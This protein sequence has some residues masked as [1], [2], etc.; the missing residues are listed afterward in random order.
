MGEQ[1][2]RE[3]S[4]AVSAGQ[5]PK[6]FIRRPRDT[7]SSLL[8]RTVQQNQF[9][10]EALTAEFFEPLEAMIDHKPYLLSA[11]E[12]TGP[13][14]LDCIALGYLSLALVPDLSSPWMRDAMHSK[15]PLLSTYTERLRR[16]CFGDAAVE[17]GHAFLLQP[18]PTTS[19]LPWRAPERISVAA[20]STTLLDS[21][22][23]STPFLREVRRNNRLKKLAESPESG[24]A[25]VES[26]AVSQYADARKKDMYISIATVVTGLV[27][28]V[29]YMVHVGLIS[30]EQSMDEEGEEGGEGK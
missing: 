7:V 1:R 15:A 22:A 13:C 30:S 21:L 26:K 8:G 10:V 23:D 3:H 16:R 29:G 2:Q 25:G 4:A 17:V 27:A 20:V 12:D 19:P 28:M 18:S 14:S 5:I 24:F 9:R 11:D 6:N